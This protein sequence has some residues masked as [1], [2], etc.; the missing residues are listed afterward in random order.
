[1]EGHFNHVITQIYCSLSQVSLQF[2]TQTA[3]EILVSECSVILIH[4]LYIRCHC[5]PFNEWHDWWKTI[6]YD[7]FEGLISFGVVI[8]DNG[9]IALNAINQAIN[10]L[11]V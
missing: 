10:R 9:E 2:R 7:K 8:K 3:V 1:M 5:W 6:L 4:F 11:A